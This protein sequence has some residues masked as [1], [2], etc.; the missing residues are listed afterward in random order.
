MCK[1]STSRCNQHDAQHVPAAAARLAAA[2]VLLRA[3]TDSLRTDGRHVAGRLRGA[4]EPTHLRGIGDGLKQKHL[5]L[6]RIALQ[7]F[8][9]RRAHLR[10]DKSTHGTARCTPLASAPFGQYGPV[11]MTHW[12]RSKRCVL[13]H[14]TMPWAARA[15]ERQQLRPTRAIS[16]H[17]CTGH[18]QWLGAS[19]TLYPTELFSDHLARFED[20]LAA[21]AMQW[22]CAQYPLEQ[23]QAARRVT[24]PTRLQRVVALQPGALLQHVGTHAAKQRQGSASYPS[25]CNP[26]FCVAKQEKVEPSCAVRD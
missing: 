15:N 22:C 7:G 10:I 25:G 20:D 13:Q 21:P 8:E 16:Q 5:A 12:T 4:R 19:T 11:H 14:R 9:Q 1:H 18:P 6:A 17:G 23:R 24:R 26:L 3:T 2:H